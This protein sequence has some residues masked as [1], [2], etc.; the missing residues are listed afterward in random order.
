[1]GI[2]KVFH[3]NTTQRVDTLFKKKLV[4]VIQ[5]FLEWSNDNFNLDN[6]KGQGLNMS[7]AKAVVKHKS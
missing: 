7:N 6:V 1:L 3:S 2:N 5:M 4:P